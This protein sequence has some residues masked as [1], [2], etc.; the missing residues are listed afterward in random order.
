MALLAAAGTHEESRKV[1]PGDE[2]Y[3]RP[4]ALLPPPTRCRRAMG[5]DR[6]SLSVRTLEPMCG[7]NPFSPSNDG[8]A[9]LRRSTRRDVLR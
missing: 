3:V 6:S 4:A 2:E 1:H 8:F 7:I 9:V 5:N